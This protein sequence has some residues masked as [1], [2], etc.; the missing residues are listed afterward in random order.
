MYTPSK[1]S[2]AMPVRVLVVDA[3]EEFSSN[4]Y[5]TLISDAVIRSKRAE[6]EELERRFA[7]PE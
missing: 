6:Q 5:D 4:T 3:D 1:L 2:D 7:K